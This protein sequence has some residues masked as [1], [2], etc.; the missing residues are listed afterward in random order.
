MIAPTRIVKPRC[1]RCGA[2]RDYVDVDGLRASCSLCGN[3][4]ISGF[5]Q[6]GGSWCPVY[7]TFIDNQL[8]NETKPDCIQER[9][10]CG[11]CPDVAQAVIRTHH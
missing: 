3:T 8:V 5:S 9:N 11:N 10:G 4:W 7:D 2:S 1:K 6:E